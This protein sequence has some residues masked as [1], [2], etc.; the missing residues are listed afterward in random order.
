MLVLG[1]IVLAVLVDVKERR[2]VFRSRIDI[3]E[4]V[5]LVFRYDFVLFVKDLFGLFRVLSYD[6]SDV[7][8]PLDLRV[9]LELALLRMQLIIGLIELLSKPNQLILHCFSLV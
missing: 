6:A 7:G 4:G 2:E 9:R 1:T 8:E 5:G 3:V